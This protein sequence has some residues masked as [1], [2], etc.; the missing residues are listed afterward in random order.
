MLAKQVGATIRTLREAR[1]VSQVALAKRAKIGRATLRRVE[2]GAHA[3]TL[4]TL[5]RIARAL[6]V[7]VTVQM[8][9]RK[10]VMTTRGGRR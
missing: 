8:T 9:R 10:R 7:T 1:G 2:E 6:K 4:D 5:D 3:M